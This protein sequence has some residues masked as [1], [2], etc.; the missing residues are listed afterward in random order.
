MSARQGRYGRWIWLSLVLLCLL[1]GSRWLLADVW[2]ATGSTLRSGALAC[3]VVAAL[4]FLLARRSAHPSVGPWRI[5]SA[6]MAGVGLLA[7]PALGAVLQGSAANPML[8]SAALCFVPLLATVLSARRDETSA[9]LWPALTAIAGAMVLFPLSLSIS[10]AGY[11]GLFFPALA[12]GLVCKHWQGLQTPDITWCEAGWLCAGG[13]VGLVA[14][15]LLRLASSAD[16]TQQLS[17]LAVGIDCVVTTSAV[18]V[19]LQLGGRRYAAR[20]L[21]APV[22]TV[23]EGIIIFR[24]PAPGRTLLGVALLLAASL[25]LLRKAGRAGTTLSLDLR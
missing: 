22:V 1:A 19:L 23:I 16:D 11:A 8:R 9:P 24:P 3:A 7:A 25:G 12:V 18:A 5:F 2:P 15:E 4:A 17:L 20:Y 21:L 10:L 6:M 14:L 13:A